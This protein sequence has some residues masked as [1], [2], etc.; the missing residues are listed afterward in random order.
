MNIGLS[1]NKYKNA[2]IL[3]AKKADEVLALIQQIKCPCEIISMYHDGVNHVA[4]V[5]SDR[6]I[7]RK[8]VK[9]KD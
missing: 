7:L 9:K 3:S 4:L 5:V 6:K 1:L 2:I 8:I